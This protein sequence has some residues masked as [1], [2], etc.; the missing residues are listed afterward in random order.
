MRQYLLSIPNELIEAARIDGASELRIY[1][2]IVMPLCKP[3]LAALGVFTFR[4]AWDMY[5]WP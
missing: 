5:I 1:W 3:A 4:E 2:Q